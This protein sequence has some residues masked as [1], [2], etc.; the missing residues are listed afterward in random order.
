MMR[1]SLGLS[2]FLS[3]SL[4][5]GIVVFALHQQPFE[6]GDMS[7]PSYSLPPLQYAYDVRLLSF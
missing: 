7:S 5:P 6:F 4:L 1:G 3:F 2:A